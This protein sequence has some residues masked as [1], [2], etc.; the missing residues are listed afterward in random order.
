MDVLN[1]MGDVIG[2][3]VQSREQDPAHQKLRKAT[4]D[5][6]SYFVGTLLKKMHESAAKGGLFEDGSETATYRDMFDEAI[7]AEIGK[8][9]AFGIADVLYKQ[10]VVHLDGPALAPANHPAKSAQP[11][12]STQ[13][14]QAGR[15][16]SKP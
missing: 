1:G 2:H 15:G 16:P 11:T 10:L 6:E 7:A 12:Q 14:P 8:K 13:S 9:G 4:R 5:M 3:A